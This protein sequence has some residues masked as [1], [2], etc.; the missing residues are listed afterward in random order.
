MSEADLL[1]SLGGDSLMAVTCPLVVSLLGAY[2]FKRGFLTASNRKVVDKIIVEATMPC[3]IISKVLPAMN[4]ERLMLIWPLLLMV[5]IMLLYG[6][7]LGAALARCLGLVYPGASQHRGLIMVLLAFPNTFIIPLTMCLAT[8]G[9][10]DLLGLENIGVDALHQELAL[11]FFLSYSVW[12]GAVSCREWRQKAL[13]PPSIACF[14]SIALGIGWGYLNSVLHI[15]LSKLAPLLHAVDFVGQPSVPLML[16]N[17]GSGLVET[18]A[19]ISERRA[20]AK[21][22]KTRAGTGSSQATQDDNLD[23]D[24]EIASDRVEAESETSDSASTTASSKE[25]EEKKEEGREER[26]DLF[27]SK[28]AVAVEAAPAVARAAAPLPEVVYVLIPFF[29]QVVGTLLSALI[30]IGLFQNAMGITNK[31]LLLVSMWQGAGPPMVNILVMVGISGNAKKELI[32]VEAL[33]R[34]AAVLKTHPS[35]E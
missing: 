18:V 33:D 8:P 1:M 5:P 27:V 4:L 32:G 20:A 31:P 24:L 10:T 2:G 11:F 19:E 21:T 35:T 17:L 23:D 25:H 30:V 15:D 16:L 9:L 29:R 6:L 28:V 22:T 34:Y 13:N 26:S 12:R 7:S 14:I 3:L